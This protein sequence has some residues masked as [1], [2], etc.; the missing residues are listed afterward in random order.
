MKQD[1]PIKSD[2]ALM[3]QIAT[4]DMKACR[5]LSARHM[6]RSYGLACHILGNTA[7]AEDVVQDAFLRLWKIAPKWQPKAQIGTWLY[8]VIHNLC[9]DRLRKE[10]RFS[11]G[12]VPDIADPSPDP[13]QLHEQKQVHDMVS[14][15]L[16]KLPTRQRVAITLVHFDECTNKDAAQKMD[17]SVDALES[18]L[19]RGRRKLRD[20]LAP[21]KSEIEGDIS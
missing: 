1:D 9:I 16:Q 17:I 3:A 19:A 4:G 15:G 11:D 10:N 18:L 21:R 13:T 7:N 2:A 14:K 5:F 8:R 12:E 20:L 6:D